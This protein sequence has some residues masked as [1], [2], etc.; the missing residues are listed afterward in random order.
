MTLKKKLL[1][2]FLVYSFLKVF[3]LSVYLRNNIS[4]Q[5]LEFG[6]VAISAELLNKH[7]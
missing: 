2:V 6:K 5:Q 7:H 1:S 4:F 3:I